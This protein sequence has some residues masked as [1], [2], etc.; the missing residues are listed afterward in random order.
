[1]TNLLKLVFIGF[2][3]IVSVHGA[4]VLAGNCSL[5]DKS[6]AISCGL[7]AKEFGEKVKNLDDDNEDQMK[8]FRRSC[9]ALKDCTRT[10]GHCGAMQDEDTKKGFDYMN[11][12]CT[13][14]EFGATEFKSCDDKL[15]KTESKCVKDYN[16]FQIQQDLFEKSDITETCSNLFGKDNCFKKAV[17]DAC[18]ANEWEKLKQR[19]LSLND[20]VK[21]CNFEGTGGVLAGDCSLADKHHAV[22]CGLR[23]KEFGA[24]VKNLD[25]DNEDQIKE[26]RKSCDAL[27]DC[28]RTLG[29]CGAMQDEETKKGFAYMNSVCTLIEFGA[30]EFKSCDEKLDKTESKCVK[31][32]NPFQIQQDL[33]EKS[34]ITETC[35]NLFGKDNCFKKAVT[36]VCGV[37]EWEK[38]KERYLSLNDRV[39]KC[40]F[41]GIV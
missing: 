17:T 41:E 28:T 16:P 1:M 22:S 19:Y 11:S 3:F 40:N 18:G 20:R 7:R 14:I 38:L 33:F 31:D 24:Q 26:F 30:T 32:Y 10:L 5:A 37:N 12:I 35:S 13:L 25:D 27:K 8:E 34:D 9:D 29:H 36:D 23:A 21:K 39:K 4:S 2:I 15:D 6:H